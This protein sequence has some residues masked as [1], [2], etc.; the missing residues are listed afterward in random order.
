MLPVRYLIEISTE[1]SAY[2][3]FGGQVACHACDHLRQSAGTGY[4]R[5]SGR[6]IAT[7]R[8]WQPREPGNAGAG[9]RRRRRLRLEIEWPFEAIEP[10]LAPLAGRAGLNGVCLASG[11]GQESAHG[12]VRPRCR[13]RRPLP[14][15][16]GLCNRWVRSN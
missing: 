6:F 5:A 7:C 12:D 9:I 11:F 8:A 2:L 15:R 4:S 16:N 10:E 13:R 14:L 1:A 3:A